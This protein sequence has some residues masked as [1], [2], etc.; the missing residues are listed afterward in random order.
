[1]KEWKNGLQDEA[2]RWMKKQKAMDEGE[3]ERE[4]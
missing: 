4:K 2:E 3:R 1:L